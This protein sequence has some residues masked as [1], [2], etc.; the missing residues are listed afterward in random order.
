MSLLLLLNPKFCNWGA[1]IDANPDSHKKR[2]K[3][4]KE[5]EQLEK[6]A[7]TPELEKKI[8]DFN[9][10]SQVEATIRDNQLL[11]HIQKIQL[12]LAQQIEEMNEEEEIA[13]FLLM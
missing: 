8:E 12:K 11:E 1:L 2:K 9:K 6:T 10:F 3:K 5:I 4:V 7:I 13:I